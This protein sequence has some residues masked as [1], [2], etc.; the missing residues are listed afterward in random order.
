[1]KFTKKPDLGYLY[2]DLAGMDM[3]M[4]L[5]ICIALD[6]KVRSNAAL[7]GAAGGVEGI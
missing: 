3:V 7:S 2:V 4:N 1:M 6:D 5:A